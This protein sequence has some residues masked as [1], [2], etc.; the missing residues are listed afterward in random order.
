[1]WKF[2]ENKIPFAMFIAFLI[3]YSLQI[4]LHTY[5]ADVLAFAIRS[6]VNSPI[7][8]FAYLNSHTLLSGEALPNYHLGHTIILWLVYQLVPDSMSYSIGPAGF[9]SAISAALAVM[10]TYLIWINLGF[11]KRKSIFIAITFGL[12]PSFWEHATI[13]EVHSLQMLFILLFIYLFLKEKYI[14][15]SIAF[16]IANLITP[17]AGL[18]FPFIFLK[19]FNKRNLIISILIGG[20]ALI[21][22]FT[23]YYLIG[24]N[25]LL[26]LNPMGDHQA[27]RG[28]V[29]RILTLNVFILLNFGF[30]TYYFFKGSKELYLQNKY[31]L[32]KL[33]I[34]SLPQLL[35]V[36]V[37]A[38]F[39][40]EYGSFQILL[41]WAMSVPI[42]Y[43]ISTINYKSF[44]FIFAIIF[45]I[46]L[47]YS[48]WL[49]P[50]KTIGASLEEAGNWL[51]ENNYKNICLIGSWNVGINIISSCNN[52]NMDSLQNYYFDNPYPTDKD[53]LKTN[54]DELIIATG[55]KIALRK[56]LSDTN[57]PGLVIEEYNPLNDIYSGTITKLYENN[58]VC[59]YSWKR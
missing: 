7:I 52:L 36:F 20:S 33:I 29:Y 57:I 31:L 44:Y 24:A 5:K 40:I 42:G 21:L 6:T 38:G 45:S 10:L 49:S 13:G 18:A 16:L 3:F 2:L 26:L 35:L 50:H 46:A 58:F 1:M 59:L 53:L 8:D 15:S 51:S 30:F 37:S 54:K 19:N 25:L 41:F 34:F 27:E 47:T 43:Y 56:I 17:L 32:S 55:K 11:D 4:P 39:F 14:L 22:Y 23:I 9:V 12:V 48:L 28:I